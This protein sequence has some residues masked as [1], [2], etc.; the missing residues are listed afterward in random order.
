MIDRPAL[1]TIPREFHAGDI[2]I[3]EDIAAACHGSALK[4]I[5]D[6]RFSVEAFRLPLPVRCSLQLDLVAILA[7]GINPILRKGTRH[8]FTLPY[9]G[10]SLLHAPRSRR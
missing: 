3:N 5:F 9:S 4:A 8:G 1:Y 2:G 7:S 10:P 6:S